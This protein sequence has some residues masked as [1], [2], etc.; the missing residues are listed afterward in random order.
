MR[1]N[2]KTAIQIV[3]TQKSFLIV[4][5]F[6]IFFSCQTDQNN[7]QGSEETKDNTPVEWVS[8]EGKKEIKKNKKIVFVSGDEE[9]RS[10]EALPQLAKILSAYHG[11]DC[12]VLF[13]QDPEHPGVIDPNYT[14][15]IPGLA[16]LEDADLLFLFTRFRALPDEQMQYFKDYLLKGKP[17][18]GIRT[19]THAFN[20]KDST[21]LWNHWGN[22]FN[23][24]GSNWAGGFGRNILGAN[25]HTH[26]GHHKHQSTR[27]IIA[28]GAE[29]NPIIKGIDDGAIWGSTDVYGVPLPLSEDIQ[30]IIMGQ[31]INRAGE[32]DEN[33]LFFGMK[34]S[35][36]EVA[37][38][39]PASKNKYNPN[40]PMMPI[41]WSKPY[42]LING[43]EG[44][45]IT[46]TTG[47]STD[48]L[49][50]ELR[51]LFI[52]SAYLLLELPVPEKARVDL[53]GTYSPTQY[54]FHDDEYWDKKNLQVKD[55]IE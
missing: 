39:N 19:S 49:N 17:I 2:E 26:H 47:S 1:Y 28:S 4:F 6:L 53:V 34:P 15:N 27:G 46:S 20:F 38:D 24:E 33:D 9:Y 44:M 45:A 51:R 21:N 40:D 25:W 12:T 11:F 50:E 23:K 52:N 54:S 16:A 30:P 22:Y 41:V 35:D 18:I 37:N 43:K 42:Q 32:F 5:L 13:A 31:V 7:Q 48:L 8:Y 36:M 14:I 3:S 29:S 10:E 55:Y